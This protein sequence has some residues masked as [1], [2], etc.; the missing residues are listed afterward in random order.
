[1]A[2]MSSISHWHASRGTVSLLCT[3]VSKV[4]CL[5]YEIFISRGSIDKISTV[6]SQNPTFASTWQKTFKHSESKEGRE[7]TE[8]RH[9][10]PPQV[11]ISSP[12]R[13]YQTM[14]SLILRSRGSPLLAAV[15]TIEQYSHAGA[16]VLCAAVFPDFSP[17]FYLS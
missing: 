1:M 12:N 7:N 16:Y 11:G 9:T 4:W 15:C 13:Q 10:L 2:S 5:Y 3:P 14:L 6:Y 17:R 8:R